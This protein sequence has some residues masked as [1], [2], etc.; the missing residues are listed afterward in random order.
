MEYFK[1]VLE[2]LKITYEFHSR[3]PTPSLEDPQL[4]AMILGYASLG[5]SI[6]HFPGAVVGSSL[7]ILF[8]YEDLI[9]RKIK[10]YFIEKD[11]KK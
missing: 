2:F 11:E 9:Y 5:G 10:N 4:A 6:A 3:W 7:P 1:S 8:K